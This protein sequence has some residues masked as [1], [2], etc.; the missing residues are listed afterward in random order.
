MHSELHLGEVTE[1]DFEHNIFNSE[2]KTGAIVILIQFLN[3]LNNR[4]MLCKL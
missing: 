3:L 4:K 2:I 1:I